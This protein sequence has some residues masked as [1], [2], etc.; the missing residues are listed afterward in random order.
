MSSNVGKPLTRPWYSSDVSQDFP[1]V[2]EPLLAGWGPSGTSVGDRFVLSESLGS[3][4][5]L[6]DAARPFFPAVSL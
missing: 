3:L 6:A 2:V 4:I 1:L 5:P